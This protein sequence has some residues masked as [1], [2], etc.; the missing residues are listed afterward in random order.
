M[1]F[2][3][4]GEM[5]GVL[6]LRDILEMI[7]KIIDNPTG[8]DNGLD[9]SEDPTYYY[10]EFKTVK[11][12]IRAWYVHEI[13]SKLERRGFDKIP[14]G[15]KAD[16]TIFNLNPHYFMEIK[17]NSLYYTYDENFKNQR[18]LFS[19]NKSGVGVIIKIVLWITYI[20]DDD[21]P[22]IFRNG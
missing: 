5:C 11:K 7:F 17:S 3:C 20:W 18:F 10:V 21:D 19:L 1:V 16:F 13:V 8:Y 9:D 14:D 4:Y 2:K 22:V 15:S 6:I 12:D